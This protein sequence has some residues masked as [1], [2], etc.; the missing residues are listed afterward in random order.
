M[1]V[2]GEEWGDA[3]N[4][5]AA[6]LEACERRDCGIT[7]DAARMVDIVTRDEDCGPASV[8]H[9]ARVIRREMGEGVARAR[10][11]E[12]WRRESWQARGVDPDALPWPTKG[13]R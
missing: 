9:V 5:L 11:V 8:R 7:A 1:I 6:A 3:V 4:E 12:A 10:G 13:E 2:A